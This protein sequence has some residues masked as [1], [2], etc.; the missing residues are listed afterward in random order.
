MHC[1]KTA[2]ANSLQ[3]RRTYAKEIKQRKLECRFAGHP[4]NRAKA[5][6][7]GIEAVIGHLE[8]DHRL[9]RNY[10]KGFAGDQINVFM[11]AAAFNFKKWMRLFLCACYLCRLK[12]IVDDFIT[13]LEKPVPLL[14]L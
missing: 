5:R 10:L 6:K 4:K 11:A 9:N 13:A 3:L 1:L 7:V 2:R 8:A 14:P 12:R